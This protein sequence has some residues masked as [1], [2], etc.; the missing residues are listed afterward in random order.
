MDG[1]DK[2]VD[3]AFGG[4]AKVMPNQSGKNEVIPRYNY[5]SRAIYLG[6][7]HHIRINVITYILSFYFRPVGSQYLL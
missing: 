1:S 6:E 7:K 2:A 3:D 4:V 5:K